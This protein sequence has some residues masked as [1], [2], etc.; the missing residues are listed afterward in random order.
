MPGTY[1]VNGDG[2]NVAATGSGNQITVG[3]TGITQYC[4]QVG[5]ASDSLTQIANGTT[6]QVL[7]ATT[8]SNPSWQAGGGGS[9]FT[10]S[11]ITASQTAVINNGYICNKAG[12]LALLLPATAVVGSLLEVTGIGANTTQITQA[13]GQ[14]INFGLLSTTSGASGSLT[15]TATFDSLRLVCV[16]TDTTWNVIS[17]I[18]NWTVV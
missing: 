9:S 6:G 14:Q 8:G 13:T 12:T 15:S 11:L 2:Q 4:V 17:S 7:T 1:Y 5:G 16:A 18:G 10:W 3:L